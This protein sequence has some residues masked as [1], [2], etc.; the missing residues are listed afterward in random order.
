LIFTIPN[1][2]LKT[3]QVYAWN[4][5]N[6]PSKKTEAIDR[7]VTSVANQVNVE[8]QNTNTEIKT[9]QAQGSITQLQEK[10]IFSS[11]FRSSKY[12]TLSD[13]V[14]AQNSSTVLRGLRILWRVHYLKGSYDIDE[15][16]DKAELYGSNFT[17]FKPLISFEADLTDN[18]YHNELTYPIIY[19]GYPLDGNIRILNR[20]PDVLGITPVRAVNIVQSPDNMELN[21]DDPKYQPITSSQYY[22]YDLSNYMYY[23]FQDIQQQVANRYLSQTTIYPRMEK[24]LW[25][26]FPIML[27]GDFKVNVRYTLP[28]QPN[29]NSSKQVTLY[30]PI[31]D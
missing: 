12:N 19:E 22:L 8:G 31:G 29:I 11:Y 4:F 30:N 25:N 13:K 3:G 10:T 26:Q 5:V 18:R 21:Q 1:A 7:N 2:N 27:K 15:P 28:M 6:V 9:Q 23:D 20:T 14:A 16:F 24:I 17:G